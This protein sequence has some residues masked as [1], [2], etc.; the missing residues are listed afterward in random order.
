[1]A[2]SIHKRFIVHPYKFNMWIAI[3]SMVMIFA[4]FTS[5]YVV[6]KGDTKTWADIQL[7]QIFTLSTIVI[8]ISSLLMHAAYVSFKKGALEWYRGFMTLTFLAGAAFLSMQ[9]QGWYT[10]VA[11][12]VY[13]TDNVAGSFIYVISGAHFLHV[14]GGVIA[15]LVFSIRSFTR[16]QA[17]NIEAMKDTTINV[18][19]MATY[20]HFVDILWVY[21]FFFFMLN[22]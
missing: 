9:I 8:V 4:A 17:S 11:Q 12:G 7:P 18:E 10:L 21:L 22:R 14:A 5:A 6:K 19:V 1:M 16:Y 3:V 15:L 13:L 20:W 2:V